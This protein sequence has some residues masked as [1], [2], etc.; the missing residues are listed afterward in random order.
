M[1]KVKYTGLFTIFSY[2]SFYALFSFFLHVYTYT[3]LHFD[4]FHLIGSLLKHV[5]IIDR[6]AVQKN[7]HSYKGYGH[8][9]HNG[10][11]F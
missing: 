7:L 8:L 1:L 5:L 6:G 10:H 9:P 11:V 2:A 3:R 4:T